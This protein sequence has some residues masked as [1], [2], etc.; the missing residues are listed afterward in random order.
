ME[1]EQK[2]FAFKKQKRL[3]RV[4]IGLKAQVLLAALI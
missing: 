3:K 4:N 1:S 2:A